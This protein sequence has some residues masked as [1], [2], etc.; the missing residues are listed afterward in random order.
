MAYA[1]GGVQ[2]QI[3]YS[4]GTS[5]APTAPGPR[6]GS[7]VELVGRHLA[8]PLIAAG[9]G[10]V[11]DRGRRELLVVPGDQERS[12][13]LDRDAHLIGVVEQQR[14]A[15]GDQCGLPPS[16]LGVEA[17]MQDRGVR[18]ARPRPDVAAVDQGDPELEPRQLARDRGTDVPCPDDHDLEIDAHVS[19]RHPPARGSPVRGRQP[20]S[21][22]SISAIACSLS[23]KW[24]AV[25]PSSR[26][27]STLTSTSSTNRHSAA[28]IPF[29]SRS[30]VSS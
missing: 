26:A 25:I 30:T 9:T 7:P 29:P 17:C 13:G 21:A 6:S 27:A 19:R 28:P 23:R 20:P 1:S 4:S 12:G 2:G 3:T 24:T 5:S 16:G 22:A 10:V 8:H 14:V 11:R 15:T 18:L